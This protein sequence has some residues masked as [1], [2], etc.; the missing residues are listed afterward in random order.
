MKKLLLLAG[1]LALSISTQV[2]AGET[3]TTAPKAP[4]QKCAKP[5]NNMKRPPVAPDKSVFE[6]RLKLTDEQKAQ[7]KAI[8]EK[9]FEKIKPIFD[10]MKLKHEEIE[11]VKRSNLSPEA[12]AEKITALR[13]EIRELKHQARAVKM[14][15]MKE[16]E[17]ILTDKQ[18]KELQKIKEEGRK[19]FEKAHKKPLLQIPPREELPVEKPKEK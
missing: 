1:I 6:K 3:T 17:S 18:K 5:C 4:C 16:F 14:E 12:Q 15:N 11:A 7:A 10:K 2:Y 19:K 13:K 9:G 8:H